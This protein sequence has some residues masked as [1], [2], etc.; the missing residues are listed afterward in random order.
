MKQEQMR[1]RVRALC[2]VAF[3]RYG[4]KMMRVLFCVHNVDTTVSISR[5]KLKKKK[6]EERIAKKHC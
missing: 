5:T 2:L 6:E 3:E 1:V 4:R